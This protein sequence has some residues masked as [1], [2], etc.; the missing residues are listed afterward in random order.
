MVKTVQ[1]SRAVR[2]EVLWNAGTR[3]IPKLIAKCKISRATAFR[4]KAQKINKPF[5]PRIL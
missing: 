4:W 2:F 5:W 1:I 3:T